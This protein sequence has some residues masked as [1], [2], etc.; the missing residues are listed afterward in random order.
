MSENIEIRIL[1]TEAERTVTFSVDE[2]ATVGEMLYRDDIRLAREKMVESYGLRD[3]LLNARLYP[4]VDESAKIRDWIMRAKKLSKH[5]A[6][7]EYSPIDHNLMPIT[8]IREQLEAGQVNARDALIAQEKVEE[9][10]K[11]QRH[12]KGKKGTS[13]KLIE[14]EEFEEFK[15]DF[16][17]VKGKHEKNTEDIKSKLDQLGI[18]IQLQERKLDQLCIDIQASSVI[19]SYAHYSF[20]S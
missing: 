6:S 15:K 12:A 11:K 16:E 2:N 7:I 20:Q 3:T 13:G 5:T 8:P 17:E 4:N 10:S 18:N 14:R 1:L 9:L 19:N